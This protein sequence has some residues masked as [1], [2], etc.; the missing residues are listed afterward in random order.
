MDE[1]TK[2]WNL[3]MPADLLEEVKEFAKTHNTNTSHVMRMACR[4]Y[5]EAVKRMEDEPK[6]AKNA[7]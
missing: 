5:L 6:G 2:R 7:K 1:N 3:F 4:K